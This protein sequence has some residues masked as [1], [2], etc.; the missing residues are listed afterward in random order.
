M[1]RECYLIP[2]IWYV[3]SVGRVLAE[4]APEVFVCARGARPGYR[5]LSPVVE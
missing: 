2:G 3:M 5:A 4:V 1:L